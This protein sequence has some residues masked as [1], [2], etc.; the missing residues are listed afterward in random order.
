MCATTKYVSVSCQS[1]G[2]T[3]RITP[4]APPITNC[5]MNAATNSSGTRNSMLP[6]HSVAS[7]LKILIP[8]GTAIASDESMKKLRTGVVRGVAN[9]WCAQT[10]MP[11]KAIAPVA[12]TIAR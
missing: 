4:V 10:S 7:Q 6:R 9:M 2:K 3:A 12:I 11:R 5:A 8:V 1:T